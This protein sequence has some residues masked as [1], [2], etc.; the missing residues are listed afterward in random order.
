MNT[1]KIFHMLKKIFRDFFILFGLILLYT[2]TSPRTVIFFKVCRDNAKW[3][4]EFQLTNGD[5]VSLAHLNFVKKFVNGPDNQL[6]SKSAAI[7]PK[8]L[9]LYLFGDSYTWNLN[10]S[11]FEGL[12]T[13]HFVDRYGGGPFHLDTS[14]N[15]ILII[16]ITERNAR[17]YF[18]NE[19]ML[20]DFF[21]SG[22][23]QKTINGENPIAPGQI[24]NISKS[25]NIFPFSFFNKHINKGLEFNIFTYNFMLPLFQT[26]AVL[27]YYLFARASGDVIIS[28]DR[29][30]L[31][32]KETA[33]NE[34]QRSSYSG[35]SA[36]EISNVINNL[37]VIYEHYKGIGFKKVY[38]SI[39]PN[40]ATIMQPE[41]YNNLIPLIQN[42]KHLKMEIVDVYSVFKKCTEGIY[43]RGD[44][45]WSNKGKQIYVDLINNKLAQ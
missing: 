35:I 17:E 36:K 7:N 29:D 34:G 25:Q 40:T 8:K 10:N 30:F 12:S 4:G 19:K 11:A 28:K 31:F 42:D 2:S 6:N 38:L 13:F 15:N 41:G 23:K 3:W 32:Y 39:I 1:I 9:A 22:R 18:D 14:F 21:D 37:N 24:A 44:T 43:L 16:E 45:H 26:K 33:V 20:D 27:N 5:L